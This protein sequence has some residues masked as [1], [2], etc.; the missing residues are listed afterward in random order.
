MTRHSPGRFP[1]PEAN[2]RHFAPLKLDGSEVQV[3]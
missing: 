1:V 3:S 2:G